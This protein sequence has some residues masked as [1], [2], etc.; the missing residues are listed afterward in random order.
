MTTKIELS[1]N[2]PE[3]LAGNRFDQ[4]AAQL[5][6]DYSRS[7]LQ[8]WIKEGLL[9]VNDLKMRPRDLLVEGDALAITTELEAQEEW[10]AEELALDVVFEDEHML[11]VNKAAGVVVHPAA[12]NRA[13]TLLN[14]L[15]HRYPQLEEV[16]RAGIV[17]R[18]D[19]D[20]TGLLMVAKNLVSHT[21]LVNLLQKREISR[22]YKAVV[23]GTL[24]GGG[25]IDKPLGRHP[26][27]RKKRAIAIDGQDAVTHYKIAER[28][29]THTLVDVK[30]ETGRTHQIRVHMASINCALL[31]D[32]M[33]GGRLQIPG[34]SH[35]NLISTLRNFRRQAL[36]AQR[37]GL[38]HPI[39]GAEMSW[40]APLPA[41]MEALLEALRLDTRGES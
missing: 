11:V 39:T 4:I 10:Q 33:Y 6:P 8:S 15:L 35:E 1:A 27:N 5:F 22:E 40:S 19:K 31:G 16:P 32:P 18:L 3:S 13:G 41:D 2:V 29:R 21:K 24:T 26:V 34:A 37:L 17:H 28:F 30:L 25:T 36:H 9:R 38:I 7:R 23:R 20:T 12:G 14:G